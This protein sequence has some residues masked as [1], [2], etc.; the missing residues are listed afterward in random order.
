MSSAS[1]SLALPTSEATQG[2]ICGTRPLRVSS[3]ARAKQQLLIAGDHMDHSCMP[4][5][6]L[7][8][9]AFSANVPPNVCYIAH[10][11]KNARL[12][13]HARAHAMPPHIH[14]PQ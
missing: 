8:G 11:R 2:R 6:H 9:I 1:R 14:L 12:R 5:V 7:H 10:A 13:G 4:M 3:S